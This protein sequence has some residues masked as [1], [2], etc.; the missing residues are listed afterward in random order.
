MSSEA[1]F[2]RVPEN[3]VWLLIDQIRKEAFWSTFVLRPDAEAMVT[4][5]WRTLMLTLKL[6][7]LS[8]YEV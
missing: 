8:C 2:G 1:F 4:V 7:V 3:N 6:F 5:S